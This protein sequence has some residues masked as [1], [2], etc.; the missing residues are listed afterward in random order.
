M[1]NESWTA[2]CLPGVSQKYMLHVYIYLKHPQYGL[3]LVS[4]DHSEEAFNAC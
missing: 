2:I 3:V 4:L 1:N